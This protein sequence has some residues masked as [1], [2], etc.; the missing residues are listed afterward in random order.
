MPATPEPK[1]PDT[2]IPETKIPD[3]KSPEVKIPKAE[4]PDAKAPGTRSQDTRTPET[5]ILDTR[6][7]ATKIP[8]AT[9][10]AKT[11]DTNGSASSRVIEAVVNAAESSRSSDVESARPEQAQAAT[12]A[13]SVPPPSDSDVPVG[14]AEGAEDRSAWR[15]QLRNR[16]TDSAGSVPSDEESDRSAWRRRTST[17]PGDQAV[18]TEPV[19]PS[20]SAD[21]PQSALRPSRLRRREKT[22][23]GLADLLAEALVAYQTSH[24]DTEDEDVLP[25]YDDPSAG[26]DPIGP[27]SGRHRFPDRASAERDTH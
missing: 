17:G 13:E 14:D 18:T 26:S 9:T 1:I 19:E 24:S 22:D 6:T 20:E 8:D 27:D 15:R 2:K 11:T 12:A 21:S 5:K 25:S 3:T 16:A 23:V 10:D 4:I 7:L